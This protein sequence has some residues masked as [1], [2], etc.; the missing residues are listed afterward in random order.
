M[1]PLYMYIVIMAL[2]SLHTHRFIQI[3]T[4]NS[5]FLKLFYELLRLEISPKLLGT[6]Y[7]LINNFFYVIIQ[8]L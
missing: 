7:L 8:Y 6:Y 4:Y 1:V 5:F 3:I 2:W